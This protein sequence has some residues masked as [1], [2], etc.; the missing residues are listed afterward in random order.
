MKNFITF[1]SSHFISF[2][3]F[4]SGGCLEKQTETEQLHRFYFI[5]PLE[6]IG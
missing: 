4:V 6:R 2:G 3:L 5:I 1:Y